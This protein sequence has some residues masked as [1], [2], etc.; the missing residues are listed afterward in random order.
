MDVMQGKISGRTFHAPEP[1]CESANLTASAHTTP[2]T[3]VFYVVK[4]FWCM[5]TQFC[6][7][8]RECAMAETPSVGNGAQVDENP[9]SIASVMGIS[10]A[11][12]KRDWA[13]AKIWLR[14]ELSRSS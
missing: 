13:T 12:V 3:V 1:G 4:S 8:R 9:R 11:T 2:F 7:T 5:T 10:P 14:R 6:V